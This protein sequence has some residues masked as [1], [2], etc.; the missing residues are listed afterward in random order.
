MAKRGIDNHGRDS[1]LKRVRSTRSLSPLECKLID[2][3]TRA[4]MSSPS[5]AARDPPSDK[6]LKWK[7]LHE[8]LI[9]AQSQSEDDGDK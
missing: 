5:D 8:T 9:D 3:F 1:D 2:D 7:S 4:E 6:P